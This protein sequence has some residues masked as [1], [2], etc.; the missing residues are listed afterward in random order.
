MKKSGQLVFPKV[1][2]KSPQRHD[3]RVVSKGKDTRTKYLPQPMTYFQRN[4]LPVPFRLGH[5]SDVRDP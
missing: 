4:Q 2:K 1:M 5:T 3:D